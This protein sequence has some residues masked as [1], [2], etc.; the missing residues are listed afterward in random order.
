MMLFKFDR[1]DEDR[2]RLMGVGQFVEGPGLR[3]VFGRANQN[4]EDHA[5]KQ[6][7]VVNFVPI[8]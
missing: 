7:I 4:R 6:I 8:N 1:Q 5:L 2:I 3:H